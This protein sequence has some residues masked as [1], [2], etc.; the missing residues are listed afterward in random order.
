VLH[1][2]LPWRIE[3][4][5][6]DAVLGAVLTLFGVVITTWGRI[7]LVKAGTNV[8]PNQ[9]TIAIVHDGPFRFTRN[10]LYVGLM[11][12]LMGISLLIGTWWGL[13]ILVTVF[14]VL[15]FG[16]V[17]LE[18]RYLERKFGPDY[19]DYKRAVRRYL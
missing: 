12:V 18:E 6:W 10:P 17:L 7:T 8:N 9:P 3:R 5:P 4:R 19:L 16:Q 1:L 2:L 13:A 15:H 11:S 14:L